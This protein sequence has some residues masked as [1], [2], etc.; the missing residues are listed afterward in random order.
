MLRYGFEFETQNELD[1]YLKDHPEADPSN[2]WVK[3]DNDRPNL[4]GKAVAATLSND[5]E[6][7]SLFARARD[8]IKAAGGAL[9]KSA[10]DIARDE[11]DT[12]KRA[13]SGL[14]KLSRGERISREDVQALA[15]TALTMASV[16]LAASTGGLGGVAA[17]GAGKAK[18]MG[19]RAVTQAVARSEAGKVVTQYVR[20]RVY[21][22]VDELVSDAAGAQ[23]FLSDAYDVAQQARSLL[24]SNDGPQDPYMDR[25]AALVAEEVS[26]IL[27]ED[28]PQSVLRKSVGEFGT[29]KQGADM[30]CRSVVAQRVAAKYQEKKRVPKADGS[31]TTTIYEYGPRQ[32]ANRHKEKAS[33]IEALRESH[34]EL[35]AKVKRDL[36]AKDAK[37]RLTALAVALIDATYERVG[38]EDSA[39]NGHVGVTGWTPEHISFVPAGKATFEYVGKSGV[40][41]KKRIDDAHIVKV[42]RAVCKGKKDGETILTEGVVKITSRHVNEYLKSFD[43]TAKDL[44]GMHANCEMQDR[45]KEIRKAGPE[46]P[47]SRKARTEI[48]KRE[49]QKALKG[50][51]EAVGHEPATLRSQYLVPGLEEAYM[52]DGTVLRKL[53]K[54]AQDLTLE[55]AWAAMGDIAE[56]QSNCQG[57]DRCLRSARSDLERA[58]QF[59]PLILMPDYGSRRATKSESEREDAEAARLSRP[60]PKLKPPRDDSRRNRIQVS[61]PDTNPKRDT[62][63]SLNYKD[64]GG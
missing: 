62:D 3:D 44:R 19:A 56:A 59:S 36:E 18:Q 57:D 49:F 51:A 38:N 8:Q 34:A 2:H 26:T 4:D 22:R 15:S 25:L 50:T 32:V 39:K 9:V 46:L 35:K 33:R 16:V 20:D 11:V 47:R 64:N 14:A 61:D 40:E 43:V 45:L 48:L 29:S 21:S 17:F 63:L 7:K 54:K 12:F 42:L 28:L 6:R 23:D 52:K 10:V 13:G 5:K 53:N 41:H 60:P 24:A 27:S 37:I 1:K 58:W 31:G 30:D 55:S